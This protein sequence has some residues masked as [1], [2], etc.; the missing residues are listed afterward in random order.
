MK[1]IIFLVLLLISACVDHPIQPAAP[2]AITT[3]AE[4]GPVVVAHLRERY[5]DLSTQCSVATR[6]AFLCSGIILRGTQYSTQYHS[7]NP[8][9]AAASVSFSYLRAD[10]KFNHIYNSKSGFIFR[11]WAYLQPGQIFPK[12][13]CFFPI[14]G[15]TSGRDQSGCGQYRPIGAATRECQSQGIT[16]APQWLNHYNS[17]PGD[18]YGRQ[19]GFSVRDELD[20]AA[21]SAFN[22][23]LKAHTSVYGAIMYNELVVEKWAQDIGSILPVEAFF[24]LSTA[25]KFTAQHDQKDFYSETG[26]AVPII[27]ITLPANNTGTATFQ[28]IPAD[29]AIPISGK[30]F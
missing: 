8:N 27:L 9:P 17:T 5:N 6:P 22:E 13:L 29:Q 11:P 18:G 23:G 4:S 1:R 12:I 21:T 7:W 25:D 19:C 16:T 10:S 20:A 30:V 14:D 24:Y 26:L 3:L 15:A 28:F 2:S